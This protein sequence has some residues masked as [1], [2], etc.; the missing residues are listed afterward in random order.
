MKGSSSNNSSELLGTA[1]H[2]I[3]TR[4]R[5]PRGVDSALGDQVRR[6]KNMEMEKNRQQNCL[7]L[8]QRCG[9][10]RKKEKGKERKEETGHADF[11]RILCLIMLLTLKFQLPEINGVTVF[12]LNFLVFHCHPFTSAFLYP[13][14]LHVSFQQQICGFLKHQSDNVCI[15]HEFIYI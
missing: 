12:W 15:L 13:L 14:T 1:S 10:R 7:L 5:G 6:A 9:I 8:S 2:M 11:F 4:L 3:T